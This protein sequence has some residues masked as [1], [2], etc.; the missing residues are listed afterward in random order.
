[1]W[2]AGGLA[3]TGLVSAAITGLALA[4]LMWGLRGWRA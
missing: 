2:L 3:A 1:V 4:W